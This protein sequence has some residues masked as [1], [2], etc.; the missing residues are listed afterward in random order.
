MP[1]DP[2]ANANF[3]PANG[4]VPVAF[5]HGHG[6][7][8][9]D[10]LRPRIHQLVGGATQDCENIIYSSSDHLIAPNWTSAFNP[11]PE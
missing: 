3:V 4:L 6:K 8:L 7:M 9:L 10:G 5:E 2:P 11:P 1:V